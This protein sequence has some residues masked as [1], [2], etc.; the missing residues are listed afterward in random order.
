MS[1]S[2]CIGVCIIDWEAGLCIGC[3]RSVA[4]SEAG[5]APADG[6]ADTA[7]PPPPAPTPPREGGDGA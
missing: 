3:G 1:E 2:P 7:E 5:S 4:E 6:S